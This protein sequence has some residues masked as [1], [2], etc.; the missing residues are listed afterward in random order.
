GME[1]FAIF[2]LCGS[3]VFRFFANGTKSGLLSIVANGNLI[4][5]KHLP[6]EIFPISRVIVALINSLF[7]LIVLFIFMV[8]FGVSFQI[9]C[10]FIPLLLL[11]ETIFILGVSFILATQYVKWRDL[12]VIWTIVVSM[13]F[14]L[15]PAVYPISN[16]PSNYQLI[17]KLNPLTLLIINLRDVILYERIPSFINLLYL[18]L[19][20]LFLLGFGI[21][22]FNRGKKTFAE[23]I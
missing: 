12:N 7:D 21:F 3:I 14:W 15:V 1:N 20:S 10:L 9:L 18:T 8:I 23:K 17:Y 4:K 2:Y 13:L 19:S 16:V 5:A 22:L 11:L 6:R